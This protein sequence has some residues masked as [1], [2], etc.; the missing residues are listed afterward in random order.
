MS[1]QDKNCQIP[2]PEKYVEEMLDYI[3]YQQNLMG[4][5][6]LENSCGEGNILKQIVKRY[7]EDAKAHNYSAEDIAAGLEKDI[8]AYEIDPEKI[9]LCKRELNALIDEKGLPAV[10]WD[11]REEDFLKSKSGKYQY[12]VGN[13]PYITYHNLDDEDRVFVKETYNTCKN[14]RFDYCYA[15]IEASIHA[16]ADDG[17]MIYLIPFSIFRNRFAS[18]LRILMRDYITKIVD[19]R[20]QQVFPGITCSTALMLCEKQTEK[21]TVEYVESSKKTTIVV[22]RSILDKK[23]KK[24]IFQKNQ[25]DGRRFGDYFQV[26]NSVAT[27]CNKAFLFEA[28]GI[29]N[30]ICISGADRIERE[31]TRPATSTKIRRMCHGDGTEYRIIFPYRVENGGIIHFDEAVF[32]DTYPGAWGHLN[33]YRTELKKRKADEKAQWFEYGRNQALS[34]IGKEKLIFPMV[35]TRS[36]RA[37]ITGPDTVPCAGYFISVNGETELT[38]QDAKNVL[39]SEAFYQYVKDV[40]TPTTISS[41]RVSVHDIVEYRF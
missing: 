11:I 3:G 9:E 19:Y 26:H 32:R 25:N 18:Q 14:G 28:T 10:I 8:T 41:Y 17:K 6:V 13:P 4:Q 24:W 20:N 7:I 27:L 38:L 30:D 31:I 2:T 29:E 39:E 35:I 36:T 40:G 22:Q 23:G 12:I 34:E 21:T 1:I 37:Y 15:F 33:R 16:L 5:K